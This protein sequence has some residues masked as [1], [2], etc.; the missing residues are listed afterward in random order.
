MG[1]ALVI[2]SVFPVM[3]MIPGFSNMPQL[4]GAD[5]SAKL[6]AYITIMDSMTD[7]GKIIITS[8]SFDLFIY[9]CIGNFN[10]F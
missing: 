9:Y 2:N 6:K 7:K 1:M 8:W 10:L 4:Q 3:Q 5:G